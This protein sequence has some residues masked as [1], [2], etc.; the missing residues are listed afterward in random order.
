MPSRDQW[1]INQICSKVTCF[2]LTITQD[3]VSRF[4][5]VR[6]IFCTVARSE[7]TGTAGSGS[8]RWSRGACPGGG[9]APAGTAPPSASSWRCSPGRGPGARP[10]TTHTLE[11]VFTLLR[12]RRTV[13]ITTC[14]FMQQCSP[15]PGGGVLYRLVWQL[16]KIVRV[17]GQDRVSTL[18]CMYAPPCWEA[19][20][21][22]GRR[23]PAAG[24][25]GLWSWEH[26]VSG[27]K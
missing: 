24:G 18:Q 3:C 17:N 19:A 20:P 1:S 16:E 5:A 14:I 10:C 11:E 22:E 21:A 4:R 2:W 15:C 8:R 6:S 12:V 7:Y 26:T 13:L 25:R 27:R 23:V 9:T